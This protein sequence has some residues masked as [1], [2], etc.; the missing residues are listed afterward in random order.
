[1]TFQ[2]MLEYII[3]QKTQ[4]QLNDVEYLIVG[5]GI[6]DA[7]NSYTPASIYT[8][9]VNFIT[10]AKTYLPN[11]KIIVFPLH[12]FYWLKP[13]EH[14]RYMSILHACENMGVMTTSNFLWWTITDRSIDSGDH[15]HLTTDGYKKL[16]YNVLS[17]VN[18]S[19]GT[20]EEEIDFSMGSE[21]NNV[22]LAVT[23]K[24]NT[25]YARG[26]VQHKNSTV[27]NSQEIVAFTKGTLI[28]GTFADNMFAP[29]LYYGGSGSAISS[30]NIYNGNLMTGLPLNYDSIGSSPYIYINISWRIGINGGLTS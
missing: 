23:R 17:F 24:G 25:I 5:G 9:V 16:A 18:G 2:Q 6:N 1:M 21:F 7:L 29:A 8:A 28:T 13:I 15:V 27:A 11:A 22:T 14:Q 26:L 10:Y 4:A 20:E 12:T 19:Y 3:G 30:I